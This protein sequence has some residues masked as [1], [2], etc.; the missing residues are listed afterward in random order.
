MN[1]LISSFILTFNVLAAATVWQQALKWE[2]HRIWH[3]TVH[4]TKIRGGQIV[5]HLFQV[6]PLNVTIKSTVCNCY[7]MSVSVCD[8]NGG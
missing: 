1:A 5:V 2:N 7:V 3:Q 4:K 8:S 6:K